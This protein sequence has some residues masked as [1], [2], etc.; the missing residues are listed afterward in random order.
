MIIDCNLISYYTPEEI[1][2]YPQTRS[3]AK[4]D[5]K[6]IYRF[7]NKSDDNPILML[8]EDLIAKNGTGLKKGF[9]QV[10]LSDD[11][12]FFL[13]YQSNELK[14]KIP[15]VSISQR[16]EMPMEKTK[17][18]PKKPKKNNKGEDSKK[19]IYQHAQIKY[20]PENNC[21]ILFYER[22]NTKGVGIIKF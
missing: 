1:M 7:S 22:A 3:G 13:L 14:A 11:F 17:K 4:D 19:F 10:I 6:A 20:D 18:P 2:P 8:E 12:S 21:Y 16:K 5:D 9:Y 15:V